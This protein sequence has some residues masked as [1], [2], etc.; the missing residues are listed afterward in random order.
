MTGWG[1]LRMNRETYDA[2]ARVDVTRNG[3]NGNDMS[4]LVIPRAV[5][6][7]VGRRYLLP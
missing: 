4:A 6:A 5:F 1:G 3:V 7:P 2:S